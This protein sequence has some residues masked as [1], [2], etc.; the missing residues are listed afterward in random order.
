LA[1]V[2]EVA[3]GYEKYKWQEE[4]LSGTYFNELKARKSDA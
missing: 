1:I 4:N 3:K 2:G